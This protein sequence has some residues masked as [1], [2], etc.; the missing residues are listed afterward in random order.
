MCWVRETD[1]KQVESKLKFDELCG[2]NEIR[3]LKP[4]MWMKS[5][6]VHRK[7]QKK[8]HYG[9][10]T[11]DVTDREGHCHSVEMRGGF[12]AGLGKKEC[13]NLTPK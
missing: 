7:G 10:Y 5:A 12:V 8:A 4:R 2:K 13:H 1:S 6:V 11:M 9:C 3:T